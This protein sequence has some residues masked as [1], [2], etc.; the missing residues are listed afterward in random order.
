MNS[1][2]RVHQVLNFES[3]DRVPV[4]VNIHKQAHDR[5]R[6]HLGLP[7]SHPAPS[8][9]ME[10][11]PE[12]DL[13]R[14]LGVDLISV[15]MGGAKTQTG[16]LPLHRRDGW[17]VARKLT[18]SG[19]GGPYYEAASHPL[20]GAELGDLEDYPWPEQRPLQAAEALADHAETLFRDT[21]LAL[22][23]RFGGPVLELAA[24]LLGT[25]EWYVRLMQ[26][27]PF[28]QALLERITR[29][30]TEWDLLGI[31][32]AGNYLSIM[33]V[34]GED[35][36]MQQGPLYPP[37]AFAD[38][39]LPPLAERW[40]RVREALAKKNPTARLMLHS[41]GAMDAFI[42]DLIKAGIEVLDP[43]QPCTDG[44]SPER[45]RADF[46]GQLVFHGG[47]DVQRLLPNGSPE[48]VET[49]VKSL[50][51]GFDAGRGG[52]IAAPTHAVQGD[53]PAENVLALTHA[54]REWSSE[55][56]QP[57][58]RDELAKYLTRLGVRRASADMGLDFGEIFVEGIAD[59][60]R[61]AGHRWVVMP[62]S[63]TQT[64][65]IHAVPPMDEA[66]EVPWEEWY[67]LDGK[68]HHTVLFLR[69]RPETT[70]QFS[71]DRTDLDHLRAVLGKQWHLAQ[72]TSLKPYLS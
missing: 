6:A 23:G 3:P 39:L 65:V 57:R 64:P 24:D 52:F 60:S 68:L 30:C 31:E 72:A 33:K 69:P 18:P 4:D 9:A 5:L 53:V 34:S 25:E 62:H 12:P 36:G 71:A 43:L 49:G 13:L 15:R 17:G 67:R 26:D 1:R 63:N 22:V 54:V 59:P 46:G 41:C 51:A 61:Y 50:L 32:S 70:G 55:R 20:A 44:M 48:E 16:P 47:V 19:T 58:S 29:I 28:V 38:I 45:L 11:V 14:E 8:G 21:D 40:R 35:F 42:P 2:E 66:T 56:A 7:A 10:V 27:R 37:E